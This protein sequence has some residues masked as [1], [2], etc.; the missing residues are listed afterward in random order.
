MSEDRERILNLPGVVTAVILVLALVQLALALVPNAIANDIFA[1]LSFIPARITFAFAP[2][3]VA[4]AFAD[5]A[6]SG[7]NVSE[8]AVVL[9]G[10]GQAW[11][12]LL[13]YA[14][15]H[16]DWT[17]LTI[18]CVT[19][20]AFGS[21]VARRLR[22]L[23]FLAF[24]AVGAIAGALTHLLFH[25]FDFGP[26]VGASAAISGTMA[27]VARFAFAPGA[28]LGERRFSPQRDEDGGAGGAPSTGGAP[29]LS[30]L[31][32]NRR[33]MFFLA[34]WFGV[35]MLLGL[36]PQ[37]VGASGAIAWEAHLGGFLAGL[38]LFD[39]FDPRRLAQETGPNSR[40]E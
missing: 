2:E 9:S 3:A 38:L 19:L 4:R 14:F 33:A 20:A 1:Q 10:A 12:T 17:H 37:A 18:N 35:N 30:Q 13:S 22:P 28:P 31:A 8:F 29:P 11:R 15:L 34:T 6:E 32:S 23:R 16:A 7:V 40:M 26:V 36:F 39:F 5:A 21:P 25:P 24:L 27:A